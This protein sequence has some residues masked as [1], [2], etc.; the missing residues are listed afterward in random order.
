MEIRQII[1]VLRAFKRGLTIQ[2]YNENSKTWHDI[3]NDRFTAF[4]FSK[5]VY[6]IKPRL[7]YVPF[8][9]E[10]RDLFRG[11]WVRSKDGEREFMVDL[12]S[13]K[14]AFEVTTYEEAFEHYE[15]ID[16]TPFGK[17]Q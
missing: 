6:R 13:K 5:E 9:W 12:I 3:G 1:R 16:K 14:Y 4:D 17:L 15:F 7:M 11:K 2:Y 10:D 8:T